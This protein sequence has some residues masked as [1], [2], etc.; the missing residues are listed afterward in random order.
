[1]P[2]ESILIKQTPAQVKYCHF[3][4]DPVVTVKTKEHFI[5]LYNVF[6]HT[7]CIVPRIT[8]AHT[9]IFFHCCSRCMH[10]LF[11][12]MKVVAFSFPPTT[13]SSF[14]PFIFFRMSVR[15]FF[16]FTLVCILFNK[17]KYCQVFLLLFKI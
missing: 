16:L 7:I 11:G 10:I 12:N 4:F 13:S 8:A 5:A 14:F 17:Y 3:V 15:A 1:M 9:F 6:H 2:Q